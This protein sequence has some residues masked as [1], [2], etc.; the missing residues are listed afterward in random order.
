M[1]SPLLSLLLSSP[2]TLPTAKASA[3]RDHLASCRTI[4]PCSASAQAQPDPNRVYVK[5]KKGAKAT[6]TVVPAAA[7]EASVS[8]DVS[9]KGFTAGYE[10]VAATLQE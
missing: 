4:S 7:P 6:V 1:L 2:P 8:L 5:F 9:L 3:C 10:A